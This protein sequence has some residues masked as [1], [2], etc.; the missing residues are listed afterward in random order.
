M[1][2]P[3]RG[4]PADDHRLGDAASSSERLPPKPT[5]ESALAGEGGS[6]GSSSRAEPTAAESSADL[7]KERQEVG[8]AAGS[9]RHPPHTTANDEDAP[10]QEGMSSPDEVPVLPANASGSDK[11]TTSDQATPVREDS[12]YDDRPARDKNRPPSGR[13]E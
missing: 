13:V 12:M 4:N 10:V 7:G 6:Q 3:E 1:S 9:Q 5:R 2:R 11:V 8:S